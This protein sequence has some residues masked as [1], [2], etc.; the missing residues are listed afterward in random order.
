MLYE[1][2]TKIMTGAA[3]PD[4]CD[5]VF[6][7]EDSEKVTKNTVR[8]INPRTARNICYTG[9]DYRQGDVLIKE[10]TISYNFV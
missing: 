8:C 1:V 5:C 4:G 6:K 2:I 3:V 10:G 9:E 7:V